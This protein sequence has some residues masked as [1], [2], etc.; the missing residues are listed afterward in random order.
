MSSPKTAASILGL[1]LHVST[2]SYLIARYI[3]SDNS[4][5]KERNASI[6][7][8]SSPFGQWCRKIKAWKQLVKT[9]SHF[10]EDSDIT[11]IVYLGTV[12]LY[13][14]EGLDSWFLNLFILMY[15]NSLALHWMALVLSKIYS[16]PEHLIAASSLAQLLHWTQLSLHVQLFCSRNN[17]IQI[18]EHFLLFEYANQL[19]LTFTG[20]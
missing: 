19:R 12:R 15:I 9:T 20:K 3:S 17:E 13:L 4:N 16:N 2:F 8:L 7:F 5:Q 1:P 10:Q 18:P 14:H 11:T 6:F